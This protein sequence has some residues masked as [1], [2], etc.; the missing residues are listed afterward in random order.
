MVIKTVRILAME[1]GVSRKNP[2]LKIGPEMAEGLLL[3]YE[4]KSKSPP[5]G[6]SR[7]TP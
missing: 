5:R 7:L 1:Q 6:A 2:S 3:D 4:E